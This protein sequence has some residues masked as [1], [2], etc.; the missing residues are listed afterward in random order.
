MNGA[1]LRNAAR[2]Q[3]NYDAIKNH[4]WHHKKLHSI[5]YPDCCFLW[6]ASSKSASTILASHRSSFVPMATLSAFHIEI[7]VLVQIFRLD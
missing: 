3:H 5:T 6:V 4:S 7:L 2:A 1:S